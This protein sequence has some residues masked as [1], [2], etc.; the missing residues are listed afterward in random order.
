MSGERAGAAV[1]RREA[2]C[3]RG[4]GSC[5]GK[6]VE[7]VWEVEAEAGCFAKGVVGARALGL[8]SPPPTN[9]SFLLALL[10]ARP[11]VCCFARTSFL[12][13][14]LAGTRTAAR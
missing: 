8:H 2:G 1:L 3:G 12:L 11:L 7:V 10:A 14:S 9:S 13:A 6:R 5:G 4:W